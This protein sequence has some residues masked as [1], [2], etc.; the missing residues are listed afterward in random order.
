MFKKMHGGQGCID[1]PPLVFH[2]YHFPRESLGQG[3]SDASSHLCMYV[4]LS[5]CKLLSP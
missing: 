3:F 1:K 5:I 2:Y 4:R